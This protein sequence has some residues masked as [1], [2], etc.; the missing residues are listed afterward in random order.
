MTSVG[1]CSKL[2]ALGDNNDHRLIGN[3][4]RNDLFTVSESIDHKT[5]FKANRV[6]KFQELT[7]WQTF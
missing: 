6:R 5:V 4:H 7:V 3:D 2:M 1:R